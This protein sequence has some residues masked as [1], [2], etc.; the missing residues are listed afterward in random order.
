M[1]IIDITI[2]N[3]HYKIACGDGEEHELLSLVTVL[4]ERIDIIRSNVPNCQHNLALVLAALKFADEFQELRKKMASAQLS[5]TEQA[6]AQAL[7]VITEYVNQLSTR[8]ETNA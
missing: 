5:N 6:I 2:D 7:D 8:L 1:P 4:N 3:Y